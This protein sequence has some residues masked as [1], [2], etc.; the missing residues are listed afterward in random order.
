MRINAARG[1]PG[2]VVCIDCQYWKWIDVP[3]DWAGQFKGNEKEST[4]V[5]EEICDDEL[6]I[7]HAFSGV[8][9]ALAI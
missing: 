7:L 2:C 4:I 1:F 6:R 8:P 9:G 3:M 5:I